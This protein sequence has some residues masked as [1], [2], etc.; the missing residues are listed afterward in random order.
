[1]KKWMMVLAFGMMISLFAAAG[2]NTQYCYITAEDNSVAVLCDEDNMDSL[3]TSSDKSGFSVRLGICMNNYYDADTL[4]V[5]ANGEPIEFTKNP[6]YQTDAPFADRQIVG[7][8]F[9]EKVTADI[10]VTFECEEKQIQFSF[11]ADKRNGGVVAEALKQFRFADDTSVYEAL[12][13]DSYT[14]RTTW[15]EYLE[16]EGI[17]LTGAKIGTYRFYKSVNM[18][19][20][21]LLA[22]N[23][24]RLD[25]VM[26]PERN[27]YVLFLPTNDLRTVNEVR[28]NVDAITENQMVFESLSGDIVWFNN[29]TYIGWQE[30]QQLDTVALRLHQIDGVNLDQVKVYVNDTEVM[31]NAD[32]RYSFSA[33]RLPID[34]VADENLADFDES[35]AT[36]FRVRVEGA[37][38]S[39]AANL[40]RVTVNTTQKIS[41]EG[42]YYC[43]GNTAWYEQIVSFGNPFAVQIELEVPNTL[44]YDLTI[45]MG[46]ETVLF[47]GSE[48]KALESLEWLYQGVFALTANVFQDDEV[49]GLWLVVAGAGV[50]GGVNEIDQDLEITLE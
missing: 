35:E 37:D 31:S 47:E 20:T 40:K 34:Y 15:S 25:A 22:N 5:F 33:E 12:T 9:F 32:E 23:E 27:R 48:V 19:D 18:I 11:L 46:E 14:F 44:R 3:T 29:G 50:D 6:D 8:V 10:H 13:S 45:R 42:Q 49:A 1:M 16:E 38:C 36:T 4:K 30:I 21:N 17:A 7:T 28:M 39:G 43:D 24:H 26:T 41:F 2:C